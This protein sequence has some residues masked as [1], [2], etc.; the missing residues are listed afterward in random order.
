MNR[1]R[2]RLIQWG[3]RQLAL[4][5]GCAALL[6]TAAACSSGGGSGG[7][8]TVNL[9]Y[10]SGRRRNRWLPEVDRRFEKAHPNIH[11]T[12]DSLAY[13]NYQP[14]LT[15]EFSSGGGPDVYWV[16]TPM[17]ASWLKDGVME[18]L[19]AK[20]KAAHINMSQYIP[21]LVRL[22]EFGGKIYGLPKDWDTIAYYYNVNYFKQHHITIPSSLT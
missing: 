5:G 20:I 18:D 2:K 10:A 4:L 9:T 17:I 13:N 6:V 3:P 22:H 1:K 16:N 11:V 12:I 15:P 19:T 7:S 14:K 21:S 8:G